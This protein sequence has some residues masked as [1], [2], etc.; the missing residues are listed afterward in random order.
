MTKEQI[1][2]A[3]DKDV[4][5]GRVAKENILEEQAKTLFQNG[6]IQESL[7][8]RS[9]AEKLNNYFKKQKKQEV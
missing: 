3:V 2:K 4:C 1:F 5:A 9:R 7:E 6:F 8:V